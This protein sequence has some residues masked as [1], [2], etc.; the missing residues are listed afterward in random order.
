MRLSCAS[1]YRS[2]T[3]SVP[4]FQPIKAFKLLP[5]NPRPR[6]STDKKPL[7][8]PF[9][10]ILLRITLQVQFCIFGCVSYDSAERFVLKKNS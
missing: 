9:T 1:A 5:G 2:Y 4:S 3:R 10:S 8:I 6:G 7:K